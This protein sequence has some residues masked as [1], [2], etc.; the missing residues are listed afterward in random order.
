LWPSIVP[1][2]A[3]LLINTATIVFDSSDDVSELPPACVSMMQHPFL[4]SYPAM[5][6]YLAKW[7][8]CAYL[9]HIILA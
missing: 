1:Q 4:P 7:K 5:I 3:R 9:G 8:M 6:A 2:L